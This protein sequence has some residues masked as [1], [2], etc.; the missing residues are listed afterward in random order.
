MITSQEAYFKFLVKIN[1]GSTQFNATVSE[2]VFCSLYN[3]AQRRWLNKN[4]PESTT[5]DI[6]NV[7]SIIVNVGLLPTAITEEYVEFDLPTDWFA[8]ADCFV[9]ANKDA[10]KN[11]TINIY[12]VKSISVRKLIAD[13]ST[14]PSFEFEET[15]YTI[16]HNKIK[17]YKKDFDIVSLSFNYYKEPKNIEIAGGVKFDNTP[18]QN[19]NP[20]LAEIFVDQIISEASTEYM[21]NWENPQGVQ[22]AKD[23]QL[24]EN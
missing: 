8:S 11:R 7:Q 18:T 19:I 12:Q 21:R 10:C 17:V 23:R 13:D 6:N 15:F 1:K 9:I 4:T 24:S 16:E 5:D 22:L 2:G 3:E 20:D 14:E